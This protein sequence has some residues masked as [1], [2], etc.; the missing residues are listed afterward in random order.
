MLRR[1]YFLLPDEAHTKTIVDELNLAGISKSSIHVLANEQHELKNLPRADWGQSHD[2][3]NY[4]ESTLWHGNLWLFFIALALFVASI[5]SGNYYV[6]ISMLVLMLISFFAGERFVS[7]LPNTHLDNFTSA[8]KQG[9]ILLMVDTPFY[10]ASE[11]VNRVHKHH[12]ESE[13]GGAC[14]CINAFG[15]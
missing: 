3:S 14:W 8:I 11:I 5:I 15:M 1:L 7:K 4:V 12:P 2:L 9:D 6:T 10:R 13:L